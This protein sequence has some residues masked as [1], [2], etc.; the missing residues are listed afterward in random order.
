MVEVTG[1][2]ALGQVGQGVLSMYDGSGGSGMLG[3]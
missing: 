1:K 2:V 3:G